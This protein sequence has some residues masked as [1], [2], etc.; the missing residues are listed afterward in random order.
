LEVTNVSRPIYAA[1]VIV[2]S[3]VVSGVGF[4]AARSPAPT[5]AMDEAELVAG[6]ERAMEHVVLEWDESDPRREAERRDA[7]RRFVYETYDASAWIPQSLFD[8]N[9]I[10]QAIV[11]DAEAIVRDRIG[12]VLWRGNPLVP[13]FG[14]APNAGSGSSL[15][16]TVNCLVCHTAEIDGVTYFGAGTKTFDDL[17]L[18]E[19]LKKLT[20]DRWLG[21]L[22]GT[23]DYA[24][25][26]DA[27]RI[28]TTHHHDKIDSQT[29]G[30]STAFAASH[31]ELYMRS[32]HGRMPSVDE[33]GRGDVK[34]PPLWHTAAK[35]PVGRWYS[36]GSFHGTYPLMASSMELEKDRSFDALV[37]VVIPRITSEF[38]DVLRYLKPPPYPYDIDAALAERGRVLFESSE[39]GCSGCH[40][41][42]DGAGNVDWPGVH[43][44][45]GT[46][47]DRADLVSTQFVAAFDQSPL[48]AHG[49]LERSS[50]YAAT[51]LTGVW[52]N[53]P[54]LHNGSV[55]TLHHLLGP[56]SERPRIFE[57]M[58]ARSL[59]RQRVGQPLAR[60]A[61]EARL[62][63]DER[64]RRHADDR[65]WFYVGRPGSSNAGHDVWPRIGSDE[66]RRA[67]IEYLKTL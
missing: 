34:T 40:G 38:D 15:L 51:P 16:W 45:V 33:V 52:A 11:G 27:Y 61:P 29:R 41:T 47:P 66:N 9:A 39:V 10:T 37:E 55:P 26:A 21:R 53:Y 57:V 7:L 24:V 25:A 42:Y 50:G 36:D 60:S 48:A 28:L 49:A 22:A 32:H 58:A 31:V 67:I 3:G 6:F 19:A 8:A 46:D 63:E 13:A 65:D 64:I 17:W 2:V 44:D 12:L 62:T 59:D 5:R 54:Y 30:R 56:V 1:I 18:G 20:S 23:P 43:R 35:M 14:M 4:L